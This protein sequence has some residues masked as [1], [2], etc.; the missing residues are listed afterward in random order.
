MG[1]PVEYAHAWSD[2]VS[3]IPI[4]KPEINAGCLINELQVC[5]V[6][7]SWSLTGTPCFGTWKAIF[8]LLPRPNIE[9]WNLSQTFAFGKL[10]FNGFLAENKCTKLF[11]GKIFQNAN[12]RCCNGANLYTQRTTTLFDFNWRVRGIDIVTAL[13]ATLVIRS[14]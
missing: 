7:Q 5:S 13:A 10:F 2:K 9:V 12:F 8:S 14:N 11:G 1:H 4:L 6:P 3:R